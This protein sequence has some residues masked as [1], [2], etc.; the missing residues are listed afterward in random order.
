MASQVRLNGSKRR[1]A[2]VLAA[3]LASAGLIGYWSGDPS[4]AVT[5]ESVIASSGANLDTDYPIPSGAT[6]VSPNG[7]DGAPG[8]QAAPLRSITEAISRTS[9]GGTVA[10]RGGTYR[11][12]IGT[13]NKPIT[14]QAY[15]HERPVLTGLDVITG[16]TQ[17]GSH[18]VTTIWTSP[19]PQ[20]QWRAE[21]ISSSYPVAGKV[22]QAWRNGI[23]LDQVASLSQVTSGKFFVD[24]SSRKLY[25]ADDPTTATMELAGRDKLALFSTGSDNSKIRGLRVTS[26]AP[27]HLDAKGMVVIASPGVTIEHSQFD[28]SSAAGLMT[29]AANL[30]MNHVSVVNNGSVG[31]DMNKSHNSLV[32]NSQF[33]RNNAE[34]FN[35]TACGESCTIAGIKATRGD[36]MRFINNAFVDND[37]TGWWCDIACSNVTFTGNAVSGSTVNGIFYEISSVGSFTNNYIANAARGFKVAGSDRVT[38]TDNTFVNNTQQTGI[39]DDAR[40]STSDYYG[41]ALGQSWDT[42]DLILDSNTFIGGSKTTRLL[43]NNATVQVAGPQMFAS[44]KNNTVTGNQT[45]VWCRAEG[46]CALHST[47]ASWAAASGYSFGTVATATATTSAPATTVSPT[48]ATTSAP[49]TTVSPTTTTTSGPTTVSPTTTTVAPTTTAAATTTATP[50]MTTTPVASTNLLKDPGFERGL[51]WEEFGHARLWISSSQYRSG[52]RSLGIYGRTKGVDADGATASPLPV[53][54]TVAGRTYTASCYVTSTTPID[55]RLLFQEYEQNWVRKA[56]AFRGPEVRT[57]N[58]ETWSKISVIYQAKYSGMLLPLTVY[59]TDLTRGGAKLY[60]DDCSVQA[61]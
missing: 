14:L 5:L 8:T 12:A 13:I 58:I 1:I 36:Q 59:T 47:I 42:T 57:Q 53:S 18:W 40:L 7:T 22:E 35:V 26:Y 46:S 44:A 52:H 6:F 30:M 23:K 41:A 60:V 54:S 38:I 29:A 43:D 25:V 16:W 48:T 50:T 28:N 21:E 32:Q 33:S 9:S 19:F 45:M 31:M 20:D 49:A 37:S 39:Y 55:V 34:H 51:T 27:V 61:I 56:D 17:A 11:Q 4:S 24:P 10:L 15:P 3:A 2:I